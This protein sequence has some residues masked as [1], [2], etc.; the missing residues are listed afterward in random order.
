VAAL[1]RAFPGNTPLYW[2]NVYVENE[3]N[4]DF[5]KKLS[6]NDDE[7]GQMSDFISVLF[8][9]LKHRFTK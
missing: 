2:C 4:R 1:K 6:Y 5:L 8:D 9:R 3:A 7:V